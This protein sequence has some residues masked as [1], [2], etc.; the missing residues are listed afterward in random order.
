[1]K[2][3]M[4][5]LWLG[6][7]AALGASPAALATPGDHDSKDVT[8]TVVSEPE[9]LN[10]KVNRISLPAVKEEPSQVAPSRSKGTDH[11][12]HAE[13]NHARAAFEVD[14]SVRDDGDKTPHDAGNVTQDTLDATR[15]GADH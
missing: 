3:I 10:E 14:D 6:T 9:Q 15:D 1:M 12:I 5:V 4:P 2:L 13:G 7:V 11:A 8:I